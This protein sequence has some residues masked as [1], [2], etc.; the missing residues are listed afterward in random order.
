MDD[1]I[2]FW[3]DRL[4][5]LEAAAREAAA[6]DGSHWEVEGIWDDTDVNVVDKEGD[7]MAEDKRTKISKVVSLIDR[8]TADHIALNDP[9][10]ALADVAAD[11]AIL[12]EYERRD[13]DAL[14]YLAGLEFAITLRA[15][16]FSGHADYHPQWAIGDPS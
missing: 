13:L 11:R 3:R 7:V 1:L 9:A 2:A 10:G 12:A 4:D 6:S 8:R 15:A 14:G 5:E 16:R